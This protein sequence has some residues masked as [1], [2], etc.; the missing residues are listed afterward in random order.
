MSGTP[1]LTPAT[2][3]DLL[4]RHG[5]RSSRALGQHFLADPN[6]ARR[7]VR[8]AGVAPG[9]SVLEIGPGIGSLTLALLDAGARVTALE[10]DRHVLPALAE[11]IADAP[12]VRVVEGDALEI[13]LDALLAAADPLHPPADANGW[14]LVSNLPYNV[15]TP[16]V[17]RIL[18][19]APAVRTLLV[20]MQ[21]EVGER[22]AASPG[23]RAY[24]AVTVK[25]GYYGLASV[26]GIVPPGVFYPPPKVDS[27]LV[28]I[29]R[30]ASPPI[31]VPSVDAL[32]VLV[33]A[34]FAQRR[35]M[36][37]AALRPLLGDRTIPVLTTAGVDPT[38]RAE[39]LDLDAWGAVARAAA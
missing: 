38:A 32:F 35:K 14:K 36:L 19:T 27:A 33:R 8:L 16:I 22:L 37:R 31:E 15:A 1:L 10:L 11:V 34:G 3:A 29:D 21:R 25:V 23:G 12:D 18:E 24:G 13:D 26:V 4:A 28:R 20:M 9:D 7:I 17:V 6:T 2:I 30:H 39:T 5:L